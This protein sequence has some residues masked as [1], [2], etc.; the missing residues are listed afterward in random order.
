MKIKYYNRNLL[1][2]N[3]KL[4]R[5]LNLIKEDIKGEYINLYRDVNFYVAILGSV[6]DR[7]GA[8]EFFISHVKHELPK[9][10]DNKK[11]FKELCEERS[12]EILNTGKKINILWSGGIDSTVV[13]FSLMN[14]SNDLSQ[15]TVILTPESIIESGNMFDKLIKNKINYILKP[16]KPFRKNFFDKKHDIDKELFITGCACDELNTTLRL[17]IPTDNKLHHLN[18]EDVLSPIISKDLMDFLNKSI[19][20]FPKKIKS[21]GDFLKFYHI[22]YGWYKGL[23]SWTPGLDPKYI[24]LMSSFYNTNEFQKWALWNKES[25]YNDIIKIPQKNYIYELTGDK[26]YSFSKGKGIGNPTI[27]PNNN[28]FFLL[29][30]NATLTYEDILNRK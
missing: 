12:T 23:Y 26:L 2:S 16:F 18:Y 28:W 30:D 7:T 9:N 8:N 19:K 20:A 14:K 6:F 24:S 11:S 3:Q 27:K 1:Y 29:D 4:L 21:Y 13:L 25:N 5:E 15:L 17:T 10:D 22:N